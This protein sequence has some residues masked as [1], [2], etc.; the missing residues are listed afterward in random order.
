[1][2]Y[3][4]RYQPLSY[5]LEFLKNKNFVITFFSKKFNWTG[6][7]QM[8]IEIYRK[9]NSKNTSGKLSIDG[10]FECYT[11]ERAKDDPEHVCIPEGKYPV[12]MRDSAFWGQHGYRQVPGIFDV[13]GR[14]DIEIHPANVPSELKGCVAVG[15]EQTEDGVMFSR[16]AFDVLLVKINACKDPIFVTI[17][18]EGV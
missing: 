8:E 4:G 6:Y 2:C 17:K 3:S 13:P 14:T 7:R 12:R 11:L 10:V 15:K 9:Y 18:Q 1:M 16:I 5:L